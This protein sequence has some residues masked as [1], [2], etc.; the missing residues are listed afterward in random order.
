MENCGPVQRLQD[1]LTI[2]ERTGA[3][4][5]IAAAIREQGTTV[6]FGQTP[7]NVFA[8]FDPQRNEIVVSEGTRDGS[9][10]ILVQHLVHEGTH[11]Q[12][13]RSASIDQ[14]YH[15]FRAEAEVWNQLKRDETDEQ[16]DWV[17]GMISQGEVEAKR[18]IRWLYP[19]LPEYA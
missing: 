3:G 4:Y 10:N 6:R 18:K 9:L 17:S 8:Y 5:S 16:C 2:L 19:G 15:A 13:K 7:R 12:W 1:G 11:D 14:E